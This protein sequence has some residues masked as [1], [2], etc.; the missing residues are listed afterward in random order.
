MTISEVAIVEATP[1]LVEAYYGRPS[2]FTLRGLVATI[3]GRPVGVGGISYVAGEPI[4]FSEMHDEL[5]ARR[6]DCARCF[7]ALEPLVRSFAGLAYAIACEPSSPALLKRLGFVDT[8]AE[9]TSDLLPRGPI[10]VRL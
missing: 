4:V 9:Q 6:R 10:M 5:R 2:P 3:D 1:E 8:G 7:R